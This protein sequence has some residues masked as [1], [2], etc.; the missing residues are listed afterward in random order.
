MNMK[1]DNNTRDV[2]VVVVIWISLAFMIS[3]MAKCSADSTKA[4]NQGNSTVVE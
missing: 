1:M 3:S 2:L 4:R